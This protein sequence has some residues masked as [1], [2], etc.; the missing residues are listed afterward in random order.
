M[1]VLTVHHHRK[2]GAGEGWNDFIGSQG[3]IAS[4]DTLMSLTR[5]SGDYDS[6]TLKVSGKAVQDQE[7]RMGKDGFK[8][9]I[10]GLEKEASLGSAQQKVYAFICEQGQATWSDVKEHMGYTDN[11][12]CRATEILRALLRDNLIEQEGYF[13]HPMK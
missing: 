10:V 6:L 9:S 12:K 13:Y 11:N 3:I 8:Y 4:H 2:D 7:L 1:T 5:V